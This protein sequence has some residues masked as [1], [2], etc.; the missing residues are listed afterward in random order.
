[1]LGDRIVAAKATACHWKIQVPKLDQAGAGRD[2]TDRKLR[3]VDAAACGLQDDLAGALRELTVE[4]G[5]GLLGGRVG[6]DGRASGGH[7]E[8]DP[9]PD[10]DRREIAPEVVVARGFGAW[11]LKERHQPHLFFCRFHTLPLVNF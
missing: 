6:A 7:D 5:F 2:A 4:V 10:G 1:M 3:S 8:A 9:A 11:V